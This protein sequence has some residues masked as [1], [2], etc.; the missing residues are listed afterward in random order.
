MVLSVCNSLDTLPERARHG[1]AAKLFGIG[2]ITSTSTAQTWSA[3]VD[4]FDSSNNSTYLQ[5]FYVDD[6]YY[7]GEGPVFYSIGGEGTL[8]GPPSGYIATLG[9]S[10]KALLIS[11]EHRFYGE[12]IPNGNVL[13]DNLKYLTVEQAMADLNAFTTYYKSN[14]D[15]RTQRSKW[16]V[17]GGSYPGALASW[18]RTAYPDASVGSLSSSGVV[19][20]IIDFDE[21]DMQVSAAAG[22]KCSDD[23]KRV[24]S[25]FSRTINEDSKTK[26][27]Q[28]SLSMF[29]CEKDMS[30]TDFYYMIADSWSM[31]IQYSSKTQLCSTLAKVPESAT[32][33]ERMQN[34]ADFSLEYWGKDFCSGGFYNTKQL[35]DPARWETNSRSWRWQTC[36]QV[37]YFN[38]APSRGSLRSETVNLD[39]HLSQCAQIF[40]KKMFPSSKAM[41]EKYG[42]RFPKADK[43]FYSDF[44]D[45]PWQRA[46]VSFPPGDQQP[47][48]LTYCDDC[49]HCL[50]L[51]EPKDSDPQALKDG[52]KEFEVYLQKWLQ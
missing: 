10:Y 28:S 42:G 7:D 6:Q 36:Y 26:G 15:K 33:A 30:E 14:I 21:F 25:A 16:F 22:N 34:F 19:D 49:G 9:K 5:R 37:S 32:D 44:S 41:N 2:L 18:Y 51:H 45:D 39:Y 35:S 4:N 31:A 3:Q 40:G 11:L 38:T 17:F 29:N 43:V 52:R 27:L 50:D 48:A 12:S 23:L 24:Q 8:T 47:Y 1:K 13:T 20:C 46:S